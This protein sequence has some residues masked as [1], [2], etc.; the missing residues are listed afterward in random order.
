MKKLWVFALPLVTTLGLPFVA[1]E[2]KVV[3]VA[4]EGF[5]FNPATVT[6]SAGDEVRWTN[7]DAVAHT[8]TSDGGIWDSGNL[9]QGE[10]FSFQ[11]AEAGEFPYSCTIHPAMTGVVVVQAPTLEEQLDQALSATEKYKDV[12]VALAEGYVSTEAHV[13]QMGVHYINFALLDET[14]DLKA[15]EVLLYVSREGTWVLVG[16]EYVVPGPV[17][18]EGFTGGEDVWGVHEATCHYKDGTEIPADSPDACPA[19][20]PD[21]GAEFDTWHPDLQT[22]HVWL[23]LENP[24]G[25]F[26]ELN[27]EIGPPVTAVEEATWG[28]IKVRH[29]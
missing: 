15:P 20:N 4:I 13:P 21:T 9:S 10:S 25:L 8:T 5:A 16:I 6:V 7:K 18:P 23:Y 14:F 27:P 22:L 3:D 17:P 24:D 19:T 28:K 2:A 11:F 29:R 1:V 12:E 26:A